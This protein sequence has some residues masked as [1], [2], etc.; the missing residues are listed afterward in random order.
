MTNS[1]LIFLV[2]ELRVLPKENEWVEFKSGTATSNDRLG[3]Y[4]SALSNAAC[5][6]NQPFGYLIFGIEDETHKVI[7]TTYKFK[8]AKEGNEDLELLIRRY[9]IPSIRF[10]HFT[11]DFHGHYLE[12]FKIP[13]AKGEP[14]HFKKIP[15]IRFN[16]SL[17]DLRN[18]PHYVKVIYNSE[19]DWSSNII[20]KAGLN[21]L[22]P[23]AIAIARKKFKEKKAGTPILDEI[24]RWDDAAFLDKAKITIGGKITNTAII[25]LGKPESSHLI[26][27][28]VAQITWKLDTE[29]K[30]YEHFEIPLFVS[31]NQVLSRI[32]NVKYKFFPDNQLLSVEVNKYE[33]KVILEALNNCIAHQ[34]YSQHSRIIL[35]EQINKLIFTNAGGFIEGNA[36]D[37]TLGNRTP[38]RYRNRWLANAMVNLNMIDTMGY[39][40]YRMYVEQRKRFFPLPDYTQS[41]RD[42]VV[43]EIYGHSID[44][45][46]SKLL[47]EKKDDLSLTEVILLDKVQK[48]QAITDDAAKLLKKKALIE[49]RRPNFYISAELAGIT[50]QKASYTRN[51]GLNKEFY[52]ELII[53]HIQN[54]KSASR[55]EI[56]AL[57]F[58]KLPDF[59]S[60]KQRKTK[61]HNIIFE[62]AGVKIQ[63]IGSRTKSKWILIKINK[64]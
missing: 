42:K 18:F 39:G 33:T 55:N 8:N 11:C 4:I 16:S 41:T 50:N 40:I 10:Q 52:K 44:E 53:Q 43:L 61:I 23:N 1:E 9:L 6:F 60:E 46:Y 63:N 7:G 22:D 19:E 57:L 15:Y 30:A 3:Q 36:E 45:N 54:H 20:E 29:E 35:T 49:G 13:A 5:I 47:I 37:Y 34:D 59:M 56:D 27:P 21:H 58:D 14:T 32:R 31:I 48:G 51:K 12:V 24:D 25:L 2:D 38:E 28:S 64:E 62:M 17:T 26:S